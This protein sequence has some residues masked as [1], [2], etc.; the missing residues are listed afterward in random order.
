MLR[1]ILLV[2][3]GIILDPRTRRWAMFILVVAAL[4]MLFAGST[5]LASS[6]LTPMSFLL[7]WGLCGWIT[8]GALLLA[9]WDILLLRAAARRERR[10]LEKQV[11]DRKSGEGQ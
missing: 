1:T 3:R 5:F 2:T 7:Y 10:R 11:A 6:L 8:L 9:L 4:L